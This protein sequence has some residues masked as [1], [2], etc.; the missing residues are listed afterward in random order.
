MAEEQFFSM[1]MER[2]R[3]EVEKLPPQDLTTS[4]TQHI[5]A[6]H[7]NTCDRC[8]EP[9]YPIIV[10][11][12]SPGSSLFSGGLTFWVARA[13]AHTYVKGTLVKATPDVEVKAGYR[14]EGQSFF[15]K[16]VELGALR[17]AVEEAVK[18]YGKAFAIYDGS[19][20]L[21]FLHHRPYIEAGREALE[22]YVSELSSLLQLGMK[23]DVKI[24]G[25]SK[26]SDVTYLRAHI[27]LEELLEL[28]VP[29]L[30]YYRS[31]RQM[32]EKMSE[33]TKLLLNTD[34]LRGFLKE[35]EFDISDEALYDKLMKDAGFTTPLILAPQTCYATQE[36]KMGR[37][38]WNDANLWVR[39]PETLI[40]L[41]KEIGRL[42]GLP[43]IAVTYWKPRHCLR[44][45]RL[46][47]PSN[48]LGY[49]AEC[50]DLTSDKFADSNV[51][52]RMKD[53]VAT[54]NWLDREAYGIRP[55][56]DVDEIVRLVRRRYKTAY[57]PVISE[58]LKSHGF[59]AKPRKRSV[60]E[61]FMR[62]Y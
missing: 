55:L 14:L 8:N 26:D 44:T 46:D 10:C 7:W 20:Y 23:D 61:D 38:R 22:R 48:L 45:Y 19:F 2:L 51:V 41:F 32:R 1:F 36:V 52:D 31:I 24:L 49:D 34:S 47:V 3:E 25:V 16:A 62:R 50:G 5:Y 33:E 4:F 37:R 27:I 54:L 9:D 30:S 53:L 57:E 12:G 40:P 17:R 29:E 28:D 21:V 59:D 15:T 13:V 43:P 58:E 11:D 39:P 42:Y 35:I 6:K 56:V 18:E 60:R